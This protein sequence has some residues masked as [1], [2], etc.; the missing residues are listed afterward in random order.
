MNK[1]DANKTG[2]IIAALVGAG[3]ATLSFLY[4][5]SKKSSKLELT[6]WLE[7]YIKEVQLKLKEN[8]NT[9]NLEIV[10]YIIHLLSELEEYYYNK[11]HSELEVERAN[12]INNKKEYEQLMHESIEHHDKHFAQAQKILEERL[13]ISYENVKKVLDNSPRNEVKEALEKYRKA[14]REIPEITKEKLKNA[15]IFHTKSLMN[16]NKI[17]REQLNLMT[18][19]P[20]MQDICVKMIFTNKYLLTDNLRLKFKIDEKYLPQLLKL[21]NLLEDDEVKYYLN[22][23]QKLEPVL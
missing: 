19:S 14:Y 17:A 22:E 2:L 13:N 16:N 1:M 5:W 18:R 6:P 12:S 3:V 9:L 7:E 23:K 11:K 21:H 20:D 8:N 4:Y 15:F 10:G